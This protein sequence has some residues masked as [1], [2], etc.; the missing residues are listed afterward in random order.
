L[1]RGGV[2]PALHA[3]HLKATD[4]HG[5]PNSP[6]HKVPTKLRLNSDVLES[7][8]ATGPGWQRSINARLCKAVG[9]G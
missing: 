6:A 4:H 9:L 5:R 8:R 2:N 7:F 1:T 3:V